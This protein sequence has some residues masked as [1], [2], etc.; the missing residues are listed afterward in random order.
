MT[1]MQNETLQMKRTKEP[2]LTINDPWR[3]L[4]NSIFLLFIFLFFFFF[5]LGFNADVG[6]FR[7]NFLSKS[8]F[9]QPLWMFISPTLIKFKFVG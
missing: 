3:N 5:F 1:K 6:E 8:T 2:R 9:T 4:I 7:E